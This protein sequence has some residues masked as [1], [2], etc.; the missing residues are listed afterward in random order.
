MD[1]GIPIEEVLEQMVDDWRLVMMFVFLSLIVR[2]IITPH[3]FVARSPS[4]F[5]RRFSCLV[6]GWGLVLD[7]GLVLGW[8]VRLAQGGQPQT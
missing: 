2:I 6:L 4:C 3:L 8:A 7:W 1:R 5:Q